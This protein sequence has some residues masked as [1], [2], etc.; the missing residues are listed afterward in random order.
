MPYSF[1]EENSF[2]SYLFSYLFSV[3]S[4]TTSFVLCN[5]TGQ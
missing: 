4:G 3:L 5:K 1:C 2:A